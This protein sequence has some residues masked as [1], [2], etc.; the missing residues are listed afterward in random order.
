MVMIVLLTA[1]TTSTC[2]QVYGTTHN[3]TSSARYLVGSPVQK[4]GGAV[5]PGK[6]V[7]HRNQEYLFFP[8]PF[9]IPSPFSL[10]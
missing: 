8:L 5:I 2:L 4:G 7:L 9:H 6:T 1:Q 3:G 10:P